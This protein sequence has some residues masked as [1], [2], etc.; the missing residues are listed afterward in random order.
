MIGAKR[1]WEF[2]PEIAVPA[3]QAIRGGGNHVVNEG[4]F[5]NMVI[6]KMYGLIYK[7]HLKSAAM[8]SSFESVMSNIKGSAKL[9]QSTKDKLPSV[10]HM[11]NTIK[12]LIWVTKYW[13]MDNGHVETPLNGEY[14]YARDADGNMNFVDLIMTVQ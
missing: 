10:Q 8:G 11:R 6:G 2:L 3:I 9:A 14:G 4:M 5:L 13:M 12:N 7:K 1:I